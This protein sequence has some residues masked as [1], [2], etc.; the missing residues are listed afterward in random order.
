MCYLYGLLLITDYVRVGV[1]AQ[2]SF[3]V[4]RRDINCIGIERTVQNCSYT[5]LKSHSILS[6]IDTLALVDCR[7]QL[8]CNTSCKYIHCYLLIEQQFY[9]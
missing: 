9:F 3:L 4:D 5:M 6:S 8:H 1:R 2:S 7:G